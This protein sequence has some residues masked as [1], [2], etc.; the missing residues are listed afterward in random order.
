M[1]LA[2]VDET[3]RQKWNEIVHKVLSNGLTLLI[4]LLLLI[5]SNGLHVSF[6]VLF[7]LLSKLSFD[8]VFGDLSLLLFFSRLTDL[9]LDLDSSP[10]LKVLIKR[11]IVIWFSKLKI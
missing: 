4:K 7:F 9:L 11:L 1:R 2:D 6:G 10:G 8:T 3:I 5:F